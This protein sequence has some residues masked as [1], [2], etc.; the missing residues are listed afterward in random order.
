MRRKQVQDLETALAEIV[1]TP[2]SPNAP[3]CNRTVAVEDVKVDA[4]VQPIVCQEVVVELGPQ[5]VTVV[6]DLVDTDSATHALHR[7]GYGVAKLEVRLIT[8]QV[9]I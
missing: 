7:A 3:V 8:V 6:H 9:G 2:A 4:V 5:K 1:A